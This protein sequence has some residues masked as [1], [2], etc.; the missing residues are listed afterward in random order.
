M[1][2]TL[3]EELDLTE[4]DDESKKKISEPDAEDDGEVKDAEEGQ[5]GEAAESI[6][7]QMPALEE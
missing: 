2:E 3:V 5:K 6:E 4:E 7:L 1:K